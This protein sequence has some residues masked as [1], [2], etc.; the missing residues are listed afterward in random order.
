MVKRAVARKY[1]VMPF[2]FHWWSIINK[3]GLKRSLPCGYQVL[4][5]TMLL[6]LFSWKSVCRWHHSGRWFRCWYNLK[7]YKSSEFNSY[8]SLMGSLLLSGVASS[9]G[10]CGHL[11]RPLA[12]RLNKM[13]HWSIRFQGLCL[14]EYYLLCFICLCLFSNGDLAL[15]GVFRLRYL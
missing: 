11:Q 13:L 3:S 2:F 4:Q 7:W 5:Y 8:L 14:A 12:T 9:I 1:I 6:L 15:K 10:H